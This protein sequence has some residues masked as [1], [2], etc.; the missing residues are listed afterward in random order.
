M[1]SSWRKTIENSWL[2]LV[3]SIP[4]CVAGAKRG[5]VIPMPFALPP[6]PLRYPFLCLLCRLLF[7]V[8]MV[9]TEQMEVNRKEKQGEG[10]G[11]RWEVIK[12]SSQLEMAGKPPDCLEMKIF[13]NTK[14]CVRKAQQVG[15]K[16]D[17][18]MK[19]SGKSSEVFWY[20]A[21]NSCLNPSTSHS[22]VYF[23]YFHY[24]Y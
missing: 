6:N 19:I 24:H 5:G 9:G 3:C 16:A 23:Y 11:V 2:I 22:F 15:R 18:T 21:K 1:W 12:F 13:H 14:L 7:R 17:R 20:S 4:G 8:Q 10:W